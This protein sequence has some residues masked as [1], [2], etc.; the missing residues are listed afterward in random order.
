MTLSSL[1]DFSARSF[2]IVLPRLEDSSIVMTNIIHQNNKM[3]MLEREVIFMN[4][5]EAVSGAYTPL[6]S[7]EDLS[8]HDCLSIG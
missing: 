2:C 8:R 6:T 3:R 4:L 1:I 7:R 5:A